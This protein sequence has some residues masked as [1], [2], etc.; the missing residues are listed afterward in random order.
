MHPRMAYARFTELKD[1]TDVTQHKP[2]AII[3]CFLKDQHSTEKNIGQMH[4]NNSNIWF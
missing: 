4:K 2:E 3:Y 1:R